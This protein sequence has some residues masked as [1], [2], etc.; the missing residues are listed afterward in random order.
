LLML[1]ALT[2]AIA[3]LEPLVTWAGERHG[4][5]RSEAAIGFACGAW[6]LGIGISFSF[7]VGREFYPL[8]SIPWFAKATVFQIIDSLVSNLLLPIAGVSLLIFSGWRLTTEVIL[9]ELAPISPAWF[10]A[11]R[12]LVRWLAP[13]TLLTIVALKRW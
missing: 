3:A 6:L 13:A 5:R 12:F 11:W 7:N 8:S 1:A 4:W 9:D 2:S 10:A